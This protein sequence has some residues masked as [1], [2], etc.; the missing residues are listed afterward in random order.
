MSTLWTL[1]PFLLFLGIIGIYQV[2]QS[3]RRRRRDARTETVY[4]SLTHTVNGMH[5]RTYG[6]PSTDLEKTFPEI[7]DTK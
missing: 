4:R 6:R 2:R 3:A 7:N 1:I 5:I